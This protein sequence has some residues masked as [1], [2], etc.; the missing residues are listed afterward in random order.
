MKYLFNI[1]LILFGSFSLYGQGGHY[2]TGPAGIYIKAGKEF[3]K[4]FV[5]QVDLKDPKGE[6]Q[7]VQQLKYPDHETEFRSKL[8]EASALMPYLT[9]PSEVEIE[10]AWKKAMRGNTI[11]S[12]YLDAANPLFYYALGCGTILKLP[13]SGQTVEA[14]VLRK[15]GPYGRVLGETL[16]NIPTTIKPLK[17]KLRSLT[18]N[19]QGNH[20]ILEF[21]ILEFDRMQDCK[22]IR[23]H[24]FRNNFK[25][26]RVPKSYTKK[27]GKMI[28]TVM[29]D[30]V[31]RDMPYSYFV[32]PFDLMG[33]FG[34]PSDTV[35]VNNAAEKSLRTYFRDFKANSLDKEDGIQLT[36]KLSDPEGIISIDIYRSD[37][38]DGEYKLIGSVGPGSAEYIDYSV[39]A[40]KGYFYQCQFNGN[41]IRSFPTPRIPAML[42]A[43]KPN[44]FPPAGPDA[45]VSGNTVRLTWQKQDADNHGY[46]IY[47]GNGFDGELLLYSGL[48]ASKD[49]MVSFTDSLKPS[50]TTRTYS[51]AVVD[52]NT[53]YALSSPSERVTVQIP[54]GI[55]PVPTGLTARYQDGIVLLI[56]D[57]I[58]DKNNYIT[59]YN[60]YRR[61]EDA[62]GKEV[63][64]EKLINTNPTPYGLNYLKDG[65]ITEGNTYIYSAVAIGLSPEIKSPACLP[66]ICRIP[67]NLPF[68]PSNLRIFSSEDQVLLQ[69][70]NVVGENP[71]YIIIRRLNADKTL[72]E[73]KVSYS[74][75][76]EYVDKD[77]KKGSIYYYELISVDRKGRQSKPTDPLGVTAE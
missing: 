51:Y 52:V 53:S 11:D 54:A 27:N 59:G 33:T 18:Q 12:L 73:F 21:E 29:D 41:Y 16:Y 60:I 39:E 57:N 8:L 31:I 1:L 6:W 68:S 72:T 70:D 63:E 40:V 22:V 4:T 74:D 19:P 28:L 55:L 34:I 76:S 3:P 61:V 48:I 65:N 42:H 13:S 20:V 64:K 66:A 44:L 10:I 45:S 7:R 24:L 56:W 71:E 58:F 38:Y 50:D 62:S 37:S 5:Y 23:G 35:N 25:E 47:R 67:E 14:R 69:W 2:F 9:Y 32:V 15:N 30:D 26:I 17:T 75:T 46:Y 77:I 36:W 43:S 49:T